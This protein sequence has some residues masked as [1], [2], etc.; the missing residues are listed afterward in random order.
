M[1]K[2]FLKLFPVFLAGV[3]FHAALGH[4]LH[5]RGMEEMLDEIIRQAQTAMLLALPALFI[6]AFLILFRGYLFKFFGW[7]VKATIDAAV[8]PGFNAINAAVAKDRE[9]FLT[10][11]SEM[12]QELV[13]WWS[14]SNAN[15]FIVGAILGLITAFTATVT[16]LL[17]LRQLEIMRVQVDEQ[18]TFNRATRITENVKLFYG[19]NHSPALRSAALSELFELKVKNFDL[20]D[21]KFD[22]VTAEGLDFTSFD[23]SGASFQGA[24][25]AGTNF[26]NANL[27]LT[28]FNAKTTVDQANFYRANLFQSE[29]SGVLFNEAKMF[30]VVLSNANL[31]GGGFGHASLSGIT[32]ANGPVHNYSC[33]V[34]GRASLRFGFGVSSGGQ[35]GVKPIATSFDQVEFFHTRLSGATLNGASFK[36]ADITGLHLHHANAPGANFS[37]AQIKGAYFTCAT[38][39]GASFNGASGYETLGISGTFAYSSLDNSSWKGAK[40]HDVNFS[41]ANLACADF[42]GATVPDPKEDNPSIVLAG[43]DLRGAIGLDYAVLTHACGD[44]KTKLPITIKTTL[45][46]CPENR[47]VSKTLCKFMPMESWASIPHAGSQEA[48]KSR[49]EFCET[50]NLECL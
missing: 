16:T 33:N 19:E 39:D 13:S 40:L 18:K 38:M 42:T 26:A 44:K 7:K 29:L 27:A 28:A 37:H 22:Q 15:R 6:L 34:S 5:F 17:L 9:G 50:H 30:S 46:P 48:I 11:S 31:A 36:N 12:I 47:N 35:N 32:A 20:R 8:E 41:G 4:F 43:A 45:Q 24:R 1:M 3:F 14:T 49:K 21:A 23:L 2:V 10:H 25:L